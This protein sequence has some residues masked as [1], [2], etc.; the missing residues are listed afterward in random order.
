MNAENDLPS[1]NKS[2]KFVFAILRKN[3][4]LITEVEIGEKK[5]ETGKRGNVCKE[6]A[7]YVSKRT[8]LTLV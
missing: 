2:M 5:G 3:E 4:P 8:R 1:G 6:N 7:E